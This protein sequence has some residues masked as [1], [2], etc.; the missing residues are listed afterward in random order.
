MREPERLASAGVVPVALPVIVIVLNGARRATRL[1]RHLDPIS[2]LLARAQVRRVR[3]QSAQRRLL[4]VIDDLPIVAGAALQRGEREATLSIE[5]A[6]PVTR[7]D[8]A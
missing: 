4:D 3:L 5:T 8:D 1:F 2:R 7:R 6:A